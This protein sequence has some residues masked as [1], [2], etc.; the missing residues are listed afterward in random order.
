MNSIL[1][2]FKE[3][4][5]S[6][7]LELKILEFNKS[8]RYPSSE[9]IQFESNHFAGEIF[10]YSGDEMKYCEMEFL[11]Y[12]GENYKTKI[13]EEIDPIKIE[14]RITEFLNERMNELKNV[15]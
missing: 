7:D 3:H 2:T 13:V 5:I 15:A 6:E 8:E 1:K 11:I 14:K 10:Y 4:Q 12:L 9:G